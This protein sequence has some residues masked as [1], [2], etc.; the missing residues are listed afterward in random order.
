MAKKTKYSEL[1]IN[2]IDLKSI[3]NINKW[4]NQITRLTNIYKPFIELNER[5]RVI[6][7]F[8]P[9]GLQFEKSNTFAIPF[10]TPNVFAT[11]FEKSNMFA[12]P[13]EKPNV[14]VTSFEKPNIFMNQFETLNIESLAFKNPYISS[15]QLPS[16]N[17]V[18]N[19]PELIDTISNK[20]MFFNATVNT[21]GAFNSITKQ[22]KS[23]G[24]TSL[25]KEIE[26]I[27]I[28]SENYNAGTEAV[29]SIDYINIEDETAVINDIC[30]EIGNKIINNKLELE[31]VLEVLNNKYNEFK[32]VN[33]NITKVIMWFLNVIVVQVLVGVIVST[34]MLK[35]FEEPKS[36]SE[37]KQIGYNPTNNKIVETGSV[38]YYSEVKIYEYNTDELL[39]EGY[40]SKRKFSEIKKTEETYRSV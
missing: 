16:L 22:L 33:P 35:V 13:F 24:Y 5:I 21:V 19:T 28:S 23:Q 6:E 14:F 12:T 37:Y 2:G 30:L 27:N 11:Q 36:K 29:L 34:I 15:L 9:I 20:M 25:F 3:E 10:E 40:I 32:K 7:S 17:F 4:R 39:Y 38:P 8:K 1:G 26:A 18:G 31:L